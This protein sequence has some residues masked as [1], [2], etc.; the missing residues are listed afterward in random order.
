MVARND[1]GI[2]RP[3]E[4][5]GLPRLGLVPAA[6]ASASPRPRSRRGG[7]SFGHRAELTKG[8]RVIRRVGVHQR[9][10]RVDEVGVVGLL[11]HE[12]EFRRMPARHARS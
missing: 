2:V 11:A 3:H 1:G 9:E 7:A 12:P 10:Q 4:R 8:V 5:G 6:S